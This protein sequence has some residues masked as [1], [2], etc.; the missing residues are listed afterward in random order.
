V[1]YAS[2]KIPQSF[3]R[4]LDTEVFTRSAL[5]RAAARAAQPY[6]RAHVTI[7]MYEHPDEFRLLSVTSDVDR[8]DWRWT[9]DAPED[10]AF[11]RAVYERLGQG[12][13]F[14]W[15]DVVAL[16]TREPDLR[17]INAHVV[18]KPVRSG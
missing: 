12:N 11:V 9:V 10:L 4:G 5:E 7:H 1:D 8:A 15:L 6:E 18:Q 13:D 2:N 3:P 17:S 14:S 16:L